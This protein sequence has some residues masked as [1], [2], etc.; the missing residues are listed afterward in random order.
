MEK[1]TPSLSGKAY[2]HKAYRPHIQER[3]GTNHTRS[4]YIHDPPIRFNHHIAE[5]RLRHIP[6]PVVHRRRKIRFV[7]REQPIAIPA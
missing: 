4:H 1:D 2:T 5:Y 7:E 6:V 3:V